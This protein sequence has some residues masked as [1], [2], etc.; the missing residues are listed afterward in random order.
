MR[1]FRCLVLVVVVVLLLTPQ[2][3]PGQNLGLGVYAPYCN[4]GLHADGYVD[5]SDL[6]PAPIGTSSNGFGAGTTTPVTATVPVRGVPGLTAT[7]SIPSLSVYAGVPA[8][9]VNGV[10]LQFNGISQ[11]TPVPVNL[12]TLSF[13]SDIRG[14]GLDVGNPGGRFDYTYNLQVGNGSA[15]PVPFSNTSLG[16]TFSLYTPMTENL[17]MVGRGVTFPSA[18]VRFFG[19]P[20]EGFG[21]PI[22]SNIR[23]QSAS[24]PDPADSIPKAG[25]QQWLRGDVGT[26]Y[27]YSTGIWPDQSGNGHDATATPDHAP[28]VTADGRTCQS[29]WLFNGSTWFDFNLPIA[30]WNEMTVFL[31]ARSTED[32]PPNS[33]NS[34][35]AAI[36][37]TENAFWGNTFISP[38]QTHVYTRFG[39]TAPNTNLSYIRP[40]AGI[41]GDF[42]ITRAVHNQGTDSV[43]VNGIRVLSKS[44]NDAVLG[45]VTGAGTI[46]KGINDTYYNGEIAEILVYDR[47]LSPQEAAQVESYLRNKYGTE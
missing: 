9:K 40:G 33:Y 45:G 28:T 31:V 26:A 27:P 23:I 38:Y 30:G 39:T 13:S 22:V 8:Y 47:V 6:P 15:V 1:S 36:L 2:I 41:G 24:A 20:G 5:F 21:Q 46:G 11:V 10:R 32:P 44:G 3:A 7:I 37:W 14:I 19:S 34:N 12:L 29:A 42:T 17:Q 25:L 16:Y 35:A 18:T 43:Y 4:A